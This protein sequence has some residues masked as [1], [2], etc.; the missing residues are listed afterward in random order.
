MVNIVKKRSEL[1]NFFTN[2]DK[3]YTKTEVLNREFAVLSFSPHDE[4]IDLISSPFDDLCVDLSTYIP[5]DTSEVY[6]KGIIVDIDRQ[7]FQTILHLQNKDINISIICKGPVLDKYSDF[8]VVGEAI[9]AKCKVFSE[10]LYLSLM[11]CINN[12]ELFNEECD[13]FTHKAHK[14]V[15][16]IMKDRWHKNKHYGLIIE[17]VLTKNKNDRDMIIGTLYDGRKNRGFATVKTKFNPAIP[18]NAM[19]G[20]FVSFKKPTMDFILNNVEVINL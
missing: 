11:I 17:C 19:A 20:N 15:Q 13:Y 16:D 4:Y 5:V 6:L 3:Q 9:I 14:I 12:L 7:K 8:F 18:R 10:K 1:I 2:E